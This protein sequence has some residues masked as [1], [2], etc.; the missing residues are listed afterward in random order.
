[1]IYFFLIQIEHNVVDFDDI[2]DPNGVH[3]LCDKMQFI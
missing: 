3:E 2:F 1:M